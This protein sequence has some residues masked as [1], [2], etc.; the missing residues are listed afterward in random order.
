M[1]LQSIKWPKRS[2]HLH[3]DLL[4]LCS[5][6]TRQ[7][8]DNGRWYTSCRNSCHPCSCASGPS[9]V[10][11]MA[12]QKIDIFIIVLS[13]D[14]SS[15]FSSSFHVFL[16]QTAHI[17]PVVITPLWLFHFFLACTLLDTFF[18]HCVTR[19]LACLYRWNKSPG[20]A[21]AAGSLGQLGSNL[22]STHLNPPPWIL[23]AKVHLRESS[24]TY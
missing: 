8:K 15:R 22:I 14:L 4:Y 18:P 7:H 21:T 13:D 5:H 19:W 2:F 20:K 17:K 11:T 16:C 24:L 10:S 23:I 9:C 1:F 12:A 3:D 6:H